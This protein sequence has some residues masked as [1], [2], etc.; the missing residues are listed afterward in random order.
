MLTTSDPV[1]AANEL[2]P[3]LLRLNRHLRRELG[4]IGIT[5][6]QAAL[7]HA[8]RTNPGIGVR[9]LATREGISAPAM[10]G[11]V[12]RLERAGLV[13]RARSD[14]DRRRVGLALTEDGLKVLRSA[15][16]RR[17][18]WLA[19]RLRRLD[20]DGLAAVEA[21]LPALYRLLEDEA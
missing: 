16:S 20:A 3:V 15:R 8:I 7:L 13:R 19:S 6:G 11:Y 21:A 2:R 12:D 18:A 4:P 17:T 14:E 10:S 9:G 5:G 1:T